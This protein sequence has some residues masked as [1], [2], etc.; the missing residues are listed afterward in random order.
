MAYATLNL[1][2]DFQG[3]SFFTAVKNCYNNMTYKEALEWIEANKNLVGTKTDL[4]KR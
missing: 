3:F 1:N 4:N 2:F